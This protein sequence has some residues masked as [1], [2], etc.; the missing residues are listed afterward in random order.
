MKSFPCR[1]NLLPF[2]PRAEGRH[3]REGSG[4][5]GPPEFILISTEGQGFRDN[6]CTG[7]A[8]VVDYVRVYDIV[9]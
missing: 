3:R 8:F 4:V 5:P 1:M 6:N 7:D 2:S 9:K